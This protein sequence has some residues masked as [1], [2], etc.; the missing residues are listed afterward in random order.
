LTSHGGCLLKGAAGVSFFVGAQ[1]VMK[2]IA[3][4]K[5][6][7]T[8][9][10]VHL[11]YLA[12]TTIKPVQ[13]L[14]ASSII[15]LAAGLSLSG[16]R[17]WQERKSA[18]S[19]GTEGLRPAR[20]IHLGHVL[21]VSAFLAISL[22][23][24]FGE[25]VFDHPDSMTR[26]HMYAAKADIAKLNKR[27]NDVSQIPTLPTQEGE[28]DLASLLGAHGQ[29]RYKDGWNTPLK[30]RAIQ[31]DGRLVYVVVSAGPD[32]TTGTEDDMTSLDN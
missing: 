25:R 17:L 19:G 21:L 28:Y 27:G 14:V 15:L 26:S 7:A 2:I 4:S 1:D 23:Y 22:A 13:G 29:G 9:P 18:K 16:R 10:F 8:T 6:P 32:R 11:G 5:V 31:R 30:L 20:R 12:T 24:V 3:C